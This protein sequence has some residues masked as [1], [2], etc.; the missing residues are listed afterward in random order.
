MLCSTALPAAAQ[1][2]APLTM[3]TLMTEKQTGVSFLNTIREDDSLNVMQ[4]EYLYNGAGVGVGDFNNDGWPD[5]FFSGNTTPGKLFLN[6]GNGQ[7]TD[8]SQAAGVAGNGTWGT[9]VSIAD[10]NGDGLTD[11]YVCH[12]GKYDDPAKL[13]NELFINQ[14]LRNGQP[15]F[16]DMAAAYGLD[17][18]GTQSTQRLFL[19]MTA[20]ATWICFC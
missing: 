2:Q 19:I 15:F 3:F 4:Y 6:R 16:K 7:F 8:I 5:L 13:S 10:V 18:P 17:A 9:G 20:T 12:S 11:I 1:K 14:G